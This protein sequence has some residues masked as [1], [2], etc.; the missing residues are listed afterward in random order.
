MVFE[1]SSTERPELYIR[2]VIRTDFFFDAGHIQ[3]FFET[4]ESS[5]L[6]VAW[7]DGESLTDSVNSVPIQTIASRSDENRAVMLSDAAAFLEAVLRMQGAK[8][9]EIEEFVSEKRALY[10]NSLNYP[11]PFHFSGALEQIFQLTIVIEKSPPIAEKLLSLAHTAT[12]TSLGILLG[13]GFSTDP[14]IMALAVPGGILLMGT[15]LGISKGLERGLARR[16]E[17]A[18]APE[19]PASRPRNRKSS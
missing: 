4:T 13:T 11:E 18:I 3:P 16:V 5:T 10:A 15:V 9:D 8:R 6:A 2:R 12:S 14:Y 1:S 7:L 19:K 17:N